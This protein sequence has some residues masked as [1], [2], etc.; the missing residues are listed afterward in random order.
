MHSEANAERFAA[1]AALIRNGNRQP[2]RWPAAEH[3]TARTRHDRAL[4]PLRQ[5]VA[6][7]LRPQR[8]LC[9]RTA[10]SVD[11]R[12]GCA[13]T[14]EHRK[15]QGNTSTPLAAQMILQSYFDERH[16]TSE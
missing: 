13:K 1:I 2:G 12:N 16:S 14:A 6:R 4:H 3:S 8:R 7:P 15:A 9:R 5:P 11:A 10:S